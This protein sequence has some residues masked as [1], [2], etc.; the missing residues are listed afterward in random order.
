MRLDRS[1]AVAALADI[2]GR[3]NLHSAEQAAQAAIDVATA[4]MA[5]EL[6]KLLAQRGDEPAKYWALPFG[7]AGP[8]HAALLA[9]EA[10]MAHIAIPLAAATFCALGAAVADVRREFVR[11]LGHGRVLA[12]AGQ[13]WKNWAQLETQAEAWLAGENIRLIGKRHLHG[14]DMRYAGQSFAI[15]TPIPD[16][17]RDAESIG[18]VVEAFHR[19][20]EA[21]YGFREGD[22]AV[23]AVTQRLS[24]IGEVPK[25][26]LP[27]LAAESTPLRPRS[28]RPVFHRDAWVDVAVYRRED[29]GAG[30]TMA[31]P[32]I[33]E[34][35]DTCIWIPPGWSATANP[36]GLLLIDRAPHDAA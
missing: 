7:G 9:A 18:G 11:G 28:R 34:Q 24:I 2:A 14:L 8:T 19:A 32:A 22:H 36:N 4:G 20:H 12:L 17:V 27:T 30:S 23:E 5:S 29:F 6:F 10:G 15:T 35:D 21:I 26:G 31:G 16:D 1:R 25:L 33:V 3:L 13:L